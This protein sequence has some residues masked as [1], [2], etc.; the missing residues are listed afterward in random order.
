MHSIAALERA[1][2]GQRARRLARYATL[3]ALAEAGLELGAQTVIARRV[4]DRWGGPDL[5]LVGNEARILALLS[6]AHGK[7]VSPSVIA[8]LRRAAK[9][10]A[11]GD[12]ALAAI[13]IA[14]T[15]LPRIDRDE[16][17]AFRL[18]AAERLLDDGLDPRDLMTGLGLDP[19]PLDAL[20][21]NQGEPRDFHGRGA[22]GG[23]R[24]AAVPT[25]PMG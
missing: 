22:D 9:A 24:P 11:R 5:A 18:F 12:K 7:P 3:P 15:G 4:R 8:N 23:T 16:G 21:Y 13:H 20:K 25:G 19:W 17:T 14:H 1:W 10:M 6:V 2:R